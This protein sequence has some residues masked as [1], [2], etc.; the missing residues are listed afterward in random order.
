M[1][2]PGVG[3]FSVD[4]QS[5][6]N[7]FVCFADGI[8]MR[9]KLFEGSS[10]SIVLVSPEFFIYFK[11]HPRGEFVFSL[12]QLW[13]FFGL[14]GAT[15][16]FSDEFSHEVGQPVSHEHSDPWL[17]SDYAKGFFFFSNR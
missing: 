1:S 10:V 11:F 8:V 13:C 14:V 7:I 15:F 3:L 12:S 4:V 17:L 16:L 9:E 5:F 2:R 6:V